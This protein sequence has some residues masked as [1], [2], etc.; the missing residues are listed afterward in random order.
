VREVTEPAACVLPTP[1]RL[2]QAMRWGAILVAGI[3][4]RV[5]NPESVPSTISRHPM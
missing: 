5:R 2:R 1:C 4:L 3:G